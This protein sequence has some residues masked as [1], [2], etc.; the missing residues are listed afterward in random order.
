MPLPFSVNTIHPDLK[1][2]KVFTQDSVVPIPFLTGIS[3]P[4]P[5]RREKSRDF[6]PA[7]DGIGIGF[8]KKIGIGTAPPDPSLG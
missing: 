2:I 7:P 3:V 5:S 1:P 8:A 4:I 6:D